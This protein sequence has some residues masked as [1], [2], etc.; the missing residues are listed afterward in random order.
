MVVCGEKGIRSSLNILTPA[1]TRL[2]NMKKNGR[3]WSERIQVVVTYF[4]SRL[5]ENGIV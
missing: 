2:Y 5:Q 3:M 1:F 4:D